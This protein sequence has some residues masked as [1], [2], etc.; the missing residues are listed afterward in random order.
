ML[1][2]N[3]VM[4]KRLNYKLCYLTLNKLAA[5]TCNLYVC[6]VQCTVYVYISVSC[7]NLLQ[8][9]RLFFAC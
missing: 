1:H 2:I 5:E 8:I 7:T 4:Y 3:F 9:L 6:T